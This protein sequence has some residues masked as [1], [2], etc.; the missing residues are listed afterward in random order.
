LVTSGLATIFIGYFIYSYAGDASTGSWLALCVDGILLA[1]G[2]YC[3]FEAIRQI[4]HL[5]SNRHESTIAPRPAGTD[6][7]GINLRG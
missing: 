5:L 2:T 6:P 7:E 4:W 1:I 3:A